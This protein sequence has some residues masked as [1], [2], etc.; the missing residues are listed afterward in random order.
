MAKKDEIYDI[1]I[2]GGG[3]S[4]MTA[5]IVSKYANP[6]LSILIL[7]K[8]DALGKKLRATGNGRCNIT[9]VSADNY[10]DTL[11]YF[12]NLS[13]LPREEDGRI[14][15]NS[16]DSRD[17]VNAL[18][19]KIC[20]LNIDIVTGVSVTK[21]TKEK[22]IFSII[23]SGSSYSSKKLLI[24]TGGK[25]APIYGT[26]GDGY[27][28]SKNFGHSITK[29]APV[30]TPVECIGD[31]K[32]LKGIR[33]KGILS[34]EL[35]EEIIFKEQG[36]IQFTDYGVSGICVFNATRFMKFIGGDGVKPYTLYFNF[37]PN[38]DMREFLNDRINKA[39]C[40]D[41]GEKVGTILRGLVKEG[42]SKRVSELANIKK[43]RAISSL[44]Q[45]EI[46]NIASIA[47]RFPLKPVRLKGWKMAQC[48]SGGITSEEINMNTFE[49]KLVENLYFAGEILDYDGPC[50]GFN[51]D[52]AWHTGTV[53]GRNMSK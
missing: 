4:G 36:E 42:I 1:C 33:S 34:L 52:Y 22:D 9:N 35:N 3:A 51:L 26:T 11:A 39:C 20:D 44:S 18:I 29:L 50:G 7:E 16:E 25:A 32:T 31:F 49:S 43:S 12:T 38:V 40:D 14:Y 37:A 46:V 10:I 17:V 47:Q 24:A 41:S 21:I 53:A 5:A 28:L 15:P 8:N 23:M 13:I 2:V 45:S 6:D 19:G 48:T 27:N 30:L